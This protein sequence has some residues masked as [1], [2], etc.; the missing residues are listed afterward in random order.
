MFNHVPV[1]LPTITATNKNG[2]RLYETPEGNKY[3]SIT[4]VLSSRNKKNVYG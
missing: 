3:P 4:T 2:V 1:E